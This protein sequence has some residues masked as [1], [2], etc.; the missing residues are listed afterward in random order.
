VSLSSQDDRGDEHSKAEKE[1]AVRMVRQ[2]QAETA[3]RQ[4]AIQRVAE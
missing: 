4:G 2:L 1:Q 3:K